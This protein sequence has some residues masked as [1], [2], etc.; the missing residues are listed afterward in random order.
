MTQEDIHNIIAIGE[1]EKTEFKSSFTDE[2][3]ISLTAF[4]NAKGGAVYI[5]IS[6]D[7]KVKGVVLGT[8]TL[9][10]WLNEI[11]NKTIPAI[12]PN[13]DVV[14][15]ED[16]KVVV[17]SVVE[18]PVKPVSVKGRH[19]Q[20]R[21]NSNHLLT[22][23]EISDLS[24]QS[25]QI[26]WDSYPHLN[27][28]FNDLNE[29]KIKEFINKVNQTG[30]FVLPESPHLALEKLGMLVKENPTN[31]AMILF[32]NKNLHYNVHIG[33]FKTPSLIIDDKMIRGNLYDVIRD[34]MQVI[35]GH[36]KFSL[37]ISIKDASTERKEIP[38][39]PLEA[40]REL[41][42]NALVHRDYLSPTDVQIRIY[43]NSIS[44]FNPSGLYGDITEQDLQTDKYRAS[45]RN[46]QLA[47]ALYLTKDI[48]KYGSG[49]IRVRKSIADYPNMKFS[50][51]NAD[52]G[53]FAELSYEPKDGELS[54]ELKDKVTN[55][56]TN[57]V[58]DKVTDNQ[59]IIINEI[60]KNNRITTQELSNILQI[61][62][63][64]TKENI[65]KLKTMGFLQRIGPAK[66]GYWQ[67]LTNENKPN[68]KE[69]IQ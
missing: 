55:K 35:V 40:I 21:V 1:G 9:Q 47:E 26:S 28:S 23:V 56:V 22:A 6:N 59:K 54:G 31:A 44:F 52:Y 30:R 41:L 4:A 7:G 49:F 2:V 39:Y 11:K 16:K 62:L 68:A 37:D 20:R 51:R 38:E 36:L 61:S 8:E 66:G 43:D 19:Y 67:L 50:Y 58:T 48:E 60:A 10:N 24:L 29:N 32:S 5:G 15:F 64:K 45:T 17:F 57:K 25:R 14:D 53:F 46:K 65:A 13:V 33:R 42:M 27:A 69:D 3:V 12:V 34:A 63:R 18:Y